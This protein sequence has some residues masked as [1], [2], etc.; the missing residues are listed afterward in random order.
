MGYA[1]TF[2]AYG[3]SSLIK[4]DGL[5]FYLRNILNV[6]FYIVHILKIYA[7]SEFTVISKHHKAF[8]SD[9]L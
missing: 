2:L 9:Y 6:S 3:L 4:A 5:L 1:G 7:C 8:V